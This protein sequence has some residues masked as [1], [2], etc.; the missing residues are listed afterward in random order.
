VLRERG[1]IGLTLKI[2]FIVPHQHADPLCAL[3][4]RLRARSKRRRRH[5]PKPCDE[6]PPSHFAI[7]RTGRGAYR[8][9][10]CKGT[11]AACCTAWGWL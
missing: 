8:G 9:G 5:R 1:E 10:G 3:A 2:A 6:L 7:P 4:R 11:G